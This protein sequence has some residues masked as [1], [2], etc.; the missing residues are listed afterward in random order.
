MTI[1][2]P[3]IPYKVVF[4]DFDGTLVDSAEQK[5]KGFFR[6]FRRTPASAEVVEEVL[7]ADP[8]G[9]R[10]EVIPRILEELSR[11]KMRVLPHWDAK[12]FIEAYS[13]TVEG[14]VTQAPEMPDATRVL[15]LLRQKSI[16]AYLC[17][18]T[19]HE[20]L[21]RL[22]EKRGWRNWFTEIAGYPTH[23]ESFVRSI[24]NATETP[25]GQAVLIGDGTSD[26]DAAR[27]TGVKYVPVSSRDTLRK[28]EKMLKDGSC[29]VR[30]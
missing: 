26:R 20:D 2:V 10:Y 5:R 1:F 21:L 13:Q 8:E 23:K 15:K 30:G 29:C 3:D 4:F 12:R 19:P 18:N 28:F 17:S 11:R 16:K 24:L 7:R 25:A 14:L 22:I 6:I 27:E 9:S